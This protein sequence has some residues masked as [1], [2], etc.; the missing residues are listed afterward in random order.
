MI[1]IKITLKGGKTMSEEIKQEISL[2]EELENQIPV[3]EESDED[4]GEEIEEGYPDVL[5]R[6]E[7]PEQS[8]PDN[9]TEPV[10]DNMPQ[11]NQNIQQVIDRCDTIVINYLCLQRP[12][13][14]RQ[15]IIIPIY[16]VALQ[17][18][19][20]HLAHDADYADVSKVASIFAQRMLSQLE[21][22]EV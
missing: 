11:E 3:E 7:D 9:A 20:Q 22:E 17:F 10:A 4:Y 5:P 8:E 19:V 6:E 16:N 2:E 13:L 15:T 1:Q 21:L 14:D 18:V 12:D